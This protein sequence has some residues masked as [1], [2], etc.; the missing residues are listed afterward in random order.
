MAL[1]RC[2]GLVVAMPQSRFQ[3][4][5]APVYGQWISRFLGGLPRLTRMWEKY[6]STVSVSSS[7]N[8]FLNLKYLCQVDEQFDLLTKSVMLILAL[9]LHWPKH[10]IVC[11]YTERYRYSTFCTYAICK[12]L[13]SNSE[14]G[15][16]SSRCT[17][18]RYSYS[19]SQEREQTPAPSS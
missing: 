4:D 6:F 15:T 3:S 12:A 19:F 14:N 5:I 11:F 8:F 13:H 18:T 9:F 16:V 7:S 17:H 10:L 1:R 2:S